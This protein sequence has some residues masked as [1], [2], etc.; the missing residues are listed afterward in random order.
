MPAALASSIAYWISGLST[1][2]SISFG[3][4]LV[5]GRKRVPSPATGNTALRTGFCIEL[6]DYNQWHNRRSWAAR[7]LRQP[8]TNKDGPVLLPS[9]EQGSPAFQLGSLRG[10]S[11][12]LKRSKIRA[13][14]RF[15]VREDSRISSTVIAADQQ[16]HSGNAS[17]CRRGRY[18]EEARI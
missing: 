2:G 8:C 10:I 17:E 12:L 6:L 18:G 1:T 4:A 13:T 16:K 14:L 15:F 9:I 3:I 5:A 11:M 7:L